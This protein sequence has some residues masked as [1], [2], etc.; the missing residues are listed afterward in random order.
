VASV[1]WFRRHLRLADN[2]ALLAVRDAGGAWVLPLF[3]PDDALR[4]PSGTPRPA[5]FY[6]RLRALD[7]ALGGRLVVLRGKPENVVHDRRVVPGQG[8]APGLDAP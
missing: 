7:E 8:P 3:V 4:R 6:R 1:L 5:F 2:P